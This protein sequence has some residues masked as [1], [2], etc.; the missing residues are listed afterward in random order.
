[1]NKHNPRPWMLASAVALAVAALC[2]ACSACAPALK[3]NRESCESIGGYWL[4]DRGDLFEVCVV[5][6]K[7]CPGFDGGRS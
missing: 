2:G 6:H 3:S 7:E 5:F 1:M 4:P